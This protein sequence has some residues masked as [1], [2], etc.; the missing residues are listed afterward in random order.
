MIS[1]KASTALTLKT[2]LCLTNSTLVLKTNPTV[3]ISF[4]TLTTQTVECSSM[5]Q[6]LSAIQ[7]IRDARIKRGSESR[8]DKKAR[9]WFKTNMQTT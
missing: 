4:R 3:Q 7:F 8:L 6:L 1:L 2:I 9:K 5:T